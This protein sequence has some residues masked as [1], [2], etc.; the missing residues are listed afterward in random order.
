MQTV[1]GENGWSKC[2]LR[3]GDRIFGDYNEGGVRGKTPYILDRF[4][5]EYMKEFDFCAYG[6]L[7]LYRITAESYERGWYKNFLRFF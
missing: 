3:D 2:T 7:L 4:D 5:L 1:V 6:K